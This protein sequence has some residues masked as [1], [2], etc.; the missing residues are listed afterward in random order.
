M[1]GPLQI[2]KLNTVTY[3]TTC[4]PY[5]ATRTIQQL[6]RDEEEHYP[7]AASV[8]IRDIYMHDILTEWDEPLS[9][10]IAKEWNYFV[11][12]LPVI[13]NIHVPRLVIG[14]DRIIIHGFTDASTAS[15][16]AVLYAESTSEEHVSTRLLCSKSRVAPEKPIT[17]PR[18]ELCACVLLS[19]LLEKRLTQNCQW[20]HVSSNENPADLISRG[21]NASDISSKQLW[22]H[23]PDF[24]RE[25][26][27]AN[28]ID[29]E[30]ITSDSDYLKELKPANVFL[31]NSRNPS[32]KRSGQLDYSEGNEA[33]LCLIKNLQ[34]SA[35]QEE[36]EFLAKSPQALLYCTRQRFWPLR[37][38]SIARKIVHECVV[39]FKNK[40]IVANQL[41]GSLPRE[42][43]NPSFPFLHTGID[44]C[45][46][47]FI[48][49]KH[50]RKGTYQ[51]IYVA[52][53]CLAS[54]AVHLEIVSD[55]T[56]DAFLATLK[57]FV[58]RCGKCATISSD[59]A[60]NFVGANRELKK[61]YIIS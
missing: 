54:K 37:V 36:I 30:R 21:L 38:R 40:P 27:E 1:C 57:R 28:P 26:L 14:K 33:E 13:Q 43:V 22:W 12:T 4:A 61:D 32:V 8:T 17:I 25:E 52:I 55:L 48:R 3:G 50:H 9:N 7:L 47:F 53:F 10:P 44:Y 58:A 42:R 16:G 31:H 23:G 19:Q 24:L 34:A 60:K 29:F 20:N 35:F 41:M 51:K 45:G 2:Y 5:L 56:A 6:A 46:P 39:C 49:Y 11:S 15:Y 18:L 59:N